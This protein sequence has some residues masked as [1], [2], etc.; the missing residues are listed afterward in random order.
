VYD[1]IVMFCVACL[2][3]L[4]GL[5]QVNVSQHLAVL[6]ERNIVTTRR[7]ETS[8]YYKIANPKITKACNILRE[9]LLEQLEDGQKLI[10]YAKDK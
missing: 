5:P 3:A 2:R 8:I 7:E 4:L 1:L 10:Q 6:R 9:A